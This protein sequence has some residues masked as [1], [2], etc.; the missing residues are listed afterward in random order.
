MTTATTNTLSTR[1]YCI[2]QLSLLGEVVL[3]S[4]AYEAMDEYERH[5]VQAVRRACNGSIYCL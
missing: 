3:P 4:V 5:A 2:S 1:D